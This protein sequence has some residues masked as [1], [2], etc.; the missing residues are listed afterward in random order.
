MQVLIAEDD[1]T[2]RERLREAVETFGHDAVVAGD[3]L[4]AWELYKRASQIDVVISAWRTPGIDGL[5]L[6]RRVRGT[7]SAGYTPFIFLA[8]PDAEMQVATV[9][10]PGADDYLTKPLD[11]E[12]LRAR[13]QAASRLTS[14]GR[15]ASTDGAE[16]DAAEANGSAHTNNG[17]PSR[18]N[19]FV[20]SKK[21]GIG[22]IR[23]WDGLVSEGRVSGEQVRRAL[24]VQEEDPQEF[25][26]IMISL[27]FI[28]ASEL[29]RA[30]ARHLKLD[31]VEL[32]ERDVDREVVALLPERLL[33]KHMVLPLRIDHAERLL[34][35]TNDPT[36]IHA[37]EDL[38]MASGR[39]IVPVLATEED[40]RRTQ[41]K[42]FAV[43]EQV[44]RILKDAAEDGVEDRSELDLGI[45]AKPNEKPIIRLVSSIL[46]QAIGEGASDIH[47]EPRTRELVVRIRVDGVLRK[48][49]SIPPKLQG[50][51]IARLKLLGS[52]DI[53]ER[54]R[55]QDGRFSV[56]MS[57][58]RVDLRVASLPAVYGEK[59]VLRLLDTTSVEADLT[60]L[61]FARR[62]LERY[63]EIFRRPHGTILVTGPT[64]S[65]KSTTL[66]ATL[67]EITSP[68]NNIITVEDPVEYR[69]PDITQMQVNPKAGLTFASALR[70]IL[71][72]DPD[73]VMIGEIRDYE[74]AKIAV[75]AALTG[76]LV[77]A[78][79]HTN[80]APGAVSR[81]TD[82]G[83]EPFLTASAVDCVIAQRLSRRLCGNC[84]EPVEPKLEIL[85][86]VGF[87]FE[88]ASDEE[89]RF[90]KAT[91][92]SRCGGTGYKGR[93]GIFEL[94]AVT[95]PI[96]EMIVRRASNAEIGRAAEET[97][98]VRLRQ[99]GLLK[100][101][102]GLTTIEEVLRT[103]L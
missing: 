40:I 2:H 93:V 91:G 20:S 43:G 56:K 45:E 29:A 50:G 88:L 63:E 51:V 70:S 62:D 47:I 5:E 84:K 55:P 35:A 4:E 81:L 101:A 15:S 94:L 14:P 71:R 86:K 12:Q 98:M 9:V 61:G 77:L 7:G 87:P 6:C 1:V 58:Q 37:I 18:R 59:I 79:L 64:G 23:F 16:P 13:L 69:M 92:C 48:I 65:G 54:R 33:R 30:Q 34:V 26:K 46:Q 24:E 53:T 83:V 68:E 73:I 25:G 39:K 103:V 85:E 75:E 32:S 28:T 78:T 44:T 99:D 10:E 22:S 52:L 97:G 66:Y 95:D 96:G 102:R 100:A 17:V 38:R 42:V 57:G 8:E 89:F 90:H 67:N 74:T 11:G 49:M 36:D 19:G 21:P 31:Y 72:T 82:M 76:H 27:G 60:K 80:D 41:A 3:G